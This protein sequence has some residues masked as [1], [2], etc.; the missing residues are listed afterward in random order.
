VLRICEEHGRFPA[1]P[2]GEPESKIW[3]IS[4]MQTT[5]HLLNHLDTATNTSITRCFDW[6]APDEQSMLQLYHLL[7]QHH[8]KAPSGDILGKF[9]NESF[10]EQ[11]NRSDNGQF[12]TPPRIV[13][14]VLDTL[15]IPAFFEINSIVNSGY[16]KSQTFLNKTVAD[17]S[18]GS[19]AF[20]TAA[21][22]RKSV[23]LKHLLTT[24]EMQQEDAL[25][26]A[27]E[28]VD[29]IETLIEEIYGKTAIQDKI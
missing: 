14:Y 18:C 10:I 6:F 27:N 15:G 21:S 5:Q 23:I 8:F 22:A 16:M 29:E 1:L 12:Y 4:S 26:K 7:Q 2:V 3:L 25:I 19:L 20:L 9:Y 11:A 24:E 28:L 17:L 13:D